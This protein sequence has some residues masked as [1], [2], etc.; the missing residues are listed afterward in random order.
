MTSRST[1]R[2]T[3]MGVLE[4]HEQQSGSWTEPARPTA[5]EPLVPIDEDKVPR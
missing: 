5:A 1:E 2:Q 4:I 3:K